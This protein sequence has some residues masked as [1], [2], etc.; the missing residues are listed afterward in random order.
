ML[1]AKKSRVHALIFLTF[2]IATMSYTVLRSSQHQGPKGTTYK[3][4]FES[5]FRLNL[6]CAT[7]K[8]ENFGGMV[9]LRL[10]HPKLGNASN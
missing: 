9:V 7:Y 2:I 4:C 3:I 8:F 10:L 1:L 6:P 5:E